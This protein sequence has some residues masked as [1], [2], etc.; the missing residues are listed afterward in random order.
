MS[1]AI[2]VL[3]ADD[4]AVVR[5]GIRRLLADRERYFV[6]GEVANAA[7]VIEAVDRWQP[8]VVVLDVRLPDGSGVEVCRAIRTARPATQVVML[9]SF[10]DDDA[11]IGAINAGAIGYVLKGTEPEHLTRAIDRAAAGEAVLDPLSARDMLAWVQRHTGPAPLDTPLSSLTEHERQVLPLI[12]RGLTNREIGEILF[13][14]DQTVKGYVSGILHKLGLARRAEIAAYVARHL[15]A[16]L[17]D[18][19]RNGTAA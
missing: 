7:E 14:S 10:T 12:A 5:L 15:P 3:V 8:D 9:T 13:V 17:T 18:Q 11:L 1:A 4:H 16:A 19:S 2:R 6:V